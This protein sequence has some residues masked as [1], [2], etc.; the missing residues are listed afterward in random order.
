MK[1]MIVVIL[2]VAM[3]GSLAF[4]Q[5]SVLSRNAVGYTK[6]A[7]PSVPGQYSLVS[8]NFNNLDQ[9]PVV[10]SN[11]LGDQLPNRSTVVLWN[12]YE[13]K[14]K[15]LTRVLGVWP[16]GTTVIT[17]GMAL[18]LRGQTN[19]GNTNYDVFFMGEVPDR[20]TATQTLVGITAS[21]GFSFVAYPYPS[22]IPFSN[23]TLA[24]TLPNRSTVAFWDPVAGY[25][26]FT[27]VL[28]VWPAGAASN[29]LQPGSGFWV[30]TTT[31]QIGFNWTE[32]KPYTWP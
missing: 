23:T 1:R 16:E 3:V 31:N 19:T 5:T 6:L 13:Q 12:N 2:A 8:L 18:F 25:S 26:R 24:A 21:G 9:S 22:P 30:Q 32:V 4:A 11:A 10:L 27:K 7:A 15:Y 29:L 14:Y 17:R 20:F 28:G